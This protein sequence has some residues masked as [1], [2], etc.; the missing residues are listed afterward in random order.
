[1][2]ISI[3]GSKAMAK[4]QFTVPY[5]QWGLKNPSLLIWKAENDV[6]IGLNLVGQIS[7]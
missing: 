3:D 5:V 6:A 1:M 4:A 7:H 2:Q